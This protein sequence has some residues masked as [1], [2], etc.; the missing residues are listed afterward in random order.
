MGTVLP[1]DDSFSPAR[2]PAGP[3]WQGM[4]R[5]S[6]DAYIKGDFQAAF[7][8]IKGVPDTLNEPRFFVYRASLLLAVGRVDE[9]NQRHRAST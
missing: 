7:E 5:N 8:A 1:A 2:F 4:V 9:A 3:G 6:I